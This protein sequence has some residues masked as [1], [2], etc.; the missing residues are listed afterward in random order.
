MRWFWNHTYEGLDVQELNRVFQ[1]AQ[2]HTLIFIPSHRAHGDY[3]AVSYLLYLNGLMIPYIAAGDNLRLPIVRYFLRGCGAFFIRRSFHDDLIYRTVLGEYLYRVLEQGNSIEF[4]VEGRRSRSGWMLPP[5]RGFMRMVVECLERGLRKP[6]C[7]VP[8]YIS[9]EK[10]VEMKSHIAELKGATKQTESIPGLLRNVR[11]FGS[12]LGSAVVRIGNPI[13]IESDD[14]DRDRSEKVSELVTSVVHNINDS[15]VVNAVNLVAF[16]TLPA[17]KQVVD[18]QILHSQIDLAREIVR[19]EADRHDYR[20]TDE[21][22]AEIIDHVVRLGF[23][24]REE[25]RYGA[26][27]SHAPNA[28]L[29]LQWH[30]NN[31]LHTVAHTALVAQVIASAQYELSDNEVFGRVAKVLPYLDAVLSTTSDADTVQRCID[32]LV[33]RGLLLRSEEAEQ[34]IKPEDPQLNFQLTLLGNLVVP[35][36]EQFYI[37]LNLI[38]NWSELDLTVESLIDRS[39]AIAQRVATILNAGPA[40]FITSDLIREFVSTLMKNGVV[41]AGSDQLVLADRN[42]QLLEVL[43]GLHRSE[44]VVAVSRFHSRDPVR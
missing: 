12:N 24:S 39:T 18:E 2:T 7:I 23:I 38:A 40:E 41:E 4:F 8:V 44:F 6:L 25:D 16:A 21:P 13:E 14:G 36:L 35:L 15:A 26:T 29:E 9:Y 30:C 27:Y 5:R 34:L 42:P 20:V 33:Q 19:A 28:T 1:Y 43:Q 17:P 10:V 37:S 32:F 31:V 3:L 11:L 22:T